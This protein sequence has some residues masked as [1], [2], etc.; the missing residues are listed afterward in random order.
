MFSSTTGI[1]TTKCYLNA[2]TFSWYVNTKIVIYQRWSRDQRVAWTRFEDSL[3]LRSR[4]PCN[5][6]TPIYQKRYRL[7]SA[8]LIP[9]QFLKSRIL[10]EFLL[11]STQWPICSLTT[12]F[13]WQIRTVLFRWKRC[14]V[15]LK[16]TYCIVFLLLLIEL[17][18]S[19]HFA[20]ES[21]W[22]TL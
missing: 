18:N 15:I 6:S 10:N 20:L 16:I 7:L 12:A 5:R 14:R 17:S 2:N 21:I 8:Y 1:R 22:Q 3:S 11:S 4:Y 19:W 13:S 9:W